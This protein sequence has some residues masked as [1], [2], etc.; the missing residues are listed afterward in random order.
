MAGKDDKQTDCGMMNAKDWDALIPVP[1]HCLVR[2]MA[3]TSAT[4]GAL[5]GTAFAR[6]V[7]IVKECVNNELKR[8]KNF[9]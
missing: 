2:L 4:N 5:P 8:T 6:D 1:Y 3:W 7:Q 9:Q